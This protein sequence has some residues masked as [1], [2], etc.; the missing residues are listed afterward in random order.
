[1]N[2]KTE[3]R[4]MYVNSIETREVTQD[5]GMVISGYITKFNTISQFMGF[6]ETVDPHAFDK[7]LADKHN[8][9]GLYNHDFDKVL[10]STKTSSLQLE[11]DNIGLKFTLT[12]NSN[13]SY[14]NDVYQLVKSGEVEG[15]SFS[16]ITNNDSWSIQDDGSDLRTLL[17]VT[18][19]EVTITPI[20]AYTDSEANTRSFNEHKAEEKKKHDDE[21]RKRRLLMELEL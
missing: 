4:K 6:Y 5:N 21:I 14:S 20:P 15:C 3:Y 11:I 12:L 8:I 10:G 16:F 2:N 18:L 9:W 17:D 19:I 13:I 1:M 7:T